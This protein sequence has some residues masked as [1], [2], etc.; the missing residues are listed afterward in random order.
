MAGRSKANLFFF[1]FTSISGMIG[2]GW[3]AGKI[4]LDEVNDEDLW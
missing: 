3:K 4:I 2:E 1:F